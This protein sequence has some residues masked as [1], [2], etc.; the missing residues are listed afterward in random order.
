M[1]DKHKRNIQNF[2]YLSSSTTQELFYPIFDAL[3]K[4]S[5]IRVR[6]CLLKSKEVLYKN[7]IIEVGIITTQTG[8]I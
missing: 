3:S 6:R 2:D 5:Q 4:E 7:K 8:D 1:E